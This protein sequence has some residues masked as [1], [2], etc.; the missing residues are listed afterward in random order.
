MDTLSKSELQ[1]RRLLAVLGG[2][3]VAIPLSQTAGFVGEGQGADG[4]GA[5][6]LVCLPV[7]PQVTEGPYWVDE[8]LFRSDIRT[9]PATGVAR[10]GVPLELTITVQNT[11]NGSCA[12]MVGAWVD[13]WHCDAIGIY[14]D[15][16][17]YNPGGG[18]GNVNTKGERFLRGYQVTD[19]NGQVKFSTIYPGW[20]SS[21]TIHIHVRVRTFSGANTVDNFVSQ[22]FF[23]EAL[24]NKVLAVAPYSNRT[25]ARD[26]TNA[27]DNVYRQAGNPER[28]LATASESGGGYAATIGLGFAFKAASA[29]T[30][31]AIGAGGVVNAASGVAGV[32]PGG[33]TTIYGTNLAT[34]ARALAASDVVNGGLPEALGGTSVRVGGQAAYPVYVSPTQ[35]NVLAPARVVSGGQEVVAVEV[36][37]SAGTGTTSAAM[38]AVLPGL[39]TAG[40]YVRAVRPA[41]GV[42]VNGTGVAEGGLPAV[43]SA[44]PGDTLELFATGLGATTYGGAANALFSGAYPTL[45][46]VTAM[47]GGQAATVL[48]AGLVGPGLYQVNVTIPAGLA[49]GAQAVV[50]GVAGVSSASAGA[51]LLVA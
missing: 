27:T 9:D 11:A 24:N 5:G 4:L 10:A 16:S 40:G 34:T 25:S 3:G 45:R 32:S 42:I 15:E 7:T 28:M 2:V 38:V 33:W 37:S 41:D 30:T 49:A 36:T 50:V 48:W 20:Y 43:A 14:S 19:G 26:T 23:D 47:V 8:K 1:R 39:F 35:V 21:R 31:P 44:R 12:P 29:T 17:T 18:T 46:A 51:V 13:I 22:V 6:G